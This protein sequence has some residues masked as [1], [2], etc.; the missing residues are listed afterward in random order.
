MSRDLDD[1]AAA[2]EQHQEAT[3]GRDH[4]H[5][6]GRS[7]GSTNGEVEHQPR[8]H[9]AGPRS[10]FNAPW[11]NDISALD[12]QVALVGV[13]YD[14]G[15][16]V[17]GLRTGS[18][19]GPN[20]V[21]D[22]RTYTYSSPE[23]GEEAQGWFD[24]EDETEY[25]KGVTI[26]DVG[27]VS[28]IPGEIVRNLDRITEVV[29][30]MAAQ[31]T[32]VGAVGG[33]HSISFPVGR[34]MARYES[35]DVVHFDAHPDYS[36]LVSGSKY[37]HGSQL[38]RLSE[39]GFINNITMIGIR[40]CSKQVWEE[41]REHGVNIVTSRQLMLEG[42][43]AAIDRTVRPS[44]FLYVSVDTD[45]LD[46]GLIPGTTLPE[47]AGIPY[48]LLRDSLIETCKKGKIVGFDIVE[49]SPPHDIGGVS[50]HITSWILTHFLSA[51]MASRA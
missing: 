19:L 31:D 14:Y 11:C 47:P 27:N 35:V 23:T 29:G 44:R 16:I 13:P 45:V 39:L 26:A 6:E 38:R 22:A 49:L 43:T 28:I 32:L 12:T 33:D 41:A 37:S 10:F 1:L 18:A 51:I 50:A 9:I 5:G 7:E 46:H 48:Q 42:A 3:G 25:L 30:R 20:A 36:D 15:T 17:P 24:I 40:R 4:H 8:I 34:G 21:R 2:E